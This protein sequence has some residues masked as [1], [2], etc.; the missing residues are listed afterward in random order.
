MAKTHKR[1]YNPFKKKAHSRKA[2]KGMDVGGMVVKGAVGG[3]VLGVGIWLS[4]KLPGALNPIVK[5]TLIL[6]L[7]IFLGLRHP[8]VKYGAIIGV[9]LIAINYGLPMIQK[10]AGGITAGG[11]SGV[12]LNG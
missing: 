6:G 3:V 11:A 5:A 7:A 8:A 12:A 4:G 2:S 9:G 10:L 1:R